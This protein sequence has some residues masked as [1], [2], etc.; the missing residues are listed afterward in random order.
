MLP[1]R[2]ISNLT[3]RLIKS[4]EHGSLYRVHHIGCFL[5]AL[6][7]DPEKEKRG[8]ETTTLLLTIAVF[9]MSSP[10]DVVLA[11][12]LLHPCLDA[13]KAGWESKDVQVCV[14]KDF[15]LTDF[16]CFARNSL[17]LKI[18]MDGYLC[19]NSA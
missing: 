4:T 3:Y 13:F 14:C 17:I 12:N 8:I 2:K 19:R 6:F 11:S 7:T 15:V 10:T 1:T 18:F 16:K 5:G 9:I